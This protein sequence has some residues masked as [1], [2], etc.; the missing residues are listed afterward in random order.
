MNVK[1]STENIRAI[2]LFEKVTGVSPKDCIIAEFSLFFL[3]DA[4]QM[5]IAIG[6]NGA[7]IKQ[8]RSISEKNIKIFPFSP[9]V[10]DFLR[11]VIPAVKTLTR[12]RDS[13]VVSV[14]K[15]D[16]ISI[17]GKRGENINAIRE[18]LKRYF[19]ITNFKLR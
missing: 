17:I 15:H 10:E 9:E 8:L 13:V 12:E 3:V 18:F 5:G 14:S 7:H 2:A 1:L 6:K 4:D 19:N 11:K 16:K